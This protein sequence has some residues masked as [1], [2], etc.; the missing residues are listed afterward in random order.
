VRADLALT[1]KAAAIPHPVS[2]AAGLLGHLATDPAQLLVIGDHHRASLFDTGTAV[3]V[4][5]GAELPLVIVNHPQGVSPAGSGSLVNRENGRENRHL[6]VVAGAGRCLRLLQEQ[7]R[8]HGHRFD[9]GR[10][11]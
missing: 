7:R 1:A 2:V 10:N 8:A 6:H 11:R 9:V 5:Q 4:L 3:D